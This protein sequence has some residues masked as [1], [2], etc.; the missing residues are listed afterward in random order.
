MKKQSLRAYGSDGSRY[1]QYHLYHEAYGVPEIREHYR[2]H[3]CKPG[4][5]DRDPWKCG[6]S[7]GCSVE[8]SYIRV[9]NDSLYFAPIIGYTGKVQEDQ[10]D[11]LNE[12]WNSSKE[13]QK[14]DAVNGVDKYDL[15]DIVGRI[16]IEKSMELDL[17]GEK[18]IPYVC[19]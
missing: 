14:S 4:D 1:D 18:A 3:Q 15:N 11:S 10:I 5:H 12:E 13:G 6:W 2:S 8:E 17:Q 7:K 9:Y 19:R 16:G